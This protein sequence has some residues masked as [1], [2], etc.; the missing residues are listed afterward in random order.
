MHVSVAAASP[1]ASSRQ[2]CNSASTVLGR[3]VPLA[4]GAVGGGTE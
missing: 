4:V 3:D 1:R 2:R